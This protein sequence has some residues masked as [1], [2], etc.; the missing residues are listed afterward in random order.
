MNAIEEIL[1]TSLYDGT[2]TEILTDYKKQRRKQS[3]K[4]KPLQSFK[5]FD[6]EAVNGEYCLLA[7]NANYI[8]SESSIS[9]E[10]ALEFLMREGRGTI[11]VFYSM[12]YDVINILRDLDDTTIKVLNKTNECFW[13]GYKISYF[14]RK[15]LT[16]IKRGH[17][18]V[19]YDVSGFWQSSYER[20]IKKTLDIE[21]EIISLGKSKRAT[22]TREDKAFLIEYNARE[23]ETLVQLCVKLREITT[24]FNL[25][26]WHGASALS[27]SVLKKIPSVKINHTRSMEFDAGLCRFIEEGYYGGRIEAFRIGR[28]ED[29]SSYDIVSAY[30]SAMRFIRSIDRIVETDTYE[31]ELA[32]IYRIDFR[33]GR[34][35]IPCPFPV[36]SNGR[37]FF[38]Q[39]GITTVTGYELGAFYDDYSKH[40]PDYHIEI[41]KGIV[42]IGSELPL[43]DEVNRLFNIRRDLKANKDAREMAYKLCLNASYGKFAQ[44]VGN[45]KFNVPFWASQITGHCRS[46]MLRLA[47]IAPDSVISFATDSVV[48]RRLPIPDSDRLKLRIGKN[49]GNLDNEHNTGI[50]IIQSGLYAWD[51]GSEAKVRGF[52]GLNFEEA[53]ENMA[54]Y[55]EHEHNAKFLVG[56]NPPK[57]IKHLRGQIIDFPKLMRLESNIKRDYGFR[58]RIDIRKSH[59]DS[60]AWVTVPDVR[61]RRDKMQPEDTVLDLEEL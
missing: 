58:R 20:A 4:T 50:R 43:A 49:L 31:P 2:P 19:F 7:S 22:F 28:V 56:L 57:S 26:S 14:P 1:D 13:N 37:I 38:P 16:I 52:R 46:E 42:S 53:Y 44:R 30:P 17:R 55:R 6:G 3:K 59:Y 9:T 48:Y 12:H 11:N 10:D 60:Q 40:F 21:D 23:C 15:I 41:Q 27:T 5:A 45:P 36:R 29:C 8:W 51:D 18:S 24:D 35:D 33:M 32:G 25:T 39:S 34:S 61:V 47:A 54:R